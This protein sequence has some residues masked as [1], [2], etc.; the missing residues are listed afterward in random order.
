MQALNSAGH[1]KMRGAKG[2]LDAVRK[3]ARAALGSDAIPEAALRTAD[4]WKFDLGQRRPQRFPI[5]L[6]SLL[7]FPRVFMIDDRVAQR[8]QA[9]ERI[10]YT[11]I[12]P[13]VCNLFRSSSRSIPAIFPGV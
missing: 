6:E 10:P 1:L 7:Q 5:L 8:C 4:D 13:N 12:N 3:G 2:L 11:H 9:R